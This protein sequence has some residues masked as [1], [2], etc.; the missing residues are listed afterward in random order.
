VTA[1]ARIKFLDKISSLEQEN[2]NLARERHQQWLGRHYPAR[3][4]EMAHQRRVRAKRRKRMRQELRLEFLRWKMNPSVRAVGHRN[5]DLAKMAQKGKANLIAG[6]WRLAHKQEMDLT[7]R[8]QPKTKT[9]V[10]APRT[11]G[12]VNSWMAVAEQLDM[13]WPAGTPAAQ[14]RNTDS[15]QRLQIRSSEE[16]PRPASTNNENYS[17]D[18]RITDT[19]CSTKI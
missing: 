2:S 9:L 13:I 18:S 17:G 16:N 3:S 1:T 10:T 6:P 8:S 5:L 15:V 7:E 14:A 12:K 4:W 19:N 11:N